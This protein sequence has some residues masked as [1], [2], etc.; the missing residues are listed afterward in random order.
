MATA[1]TGWLCTHSAS[2]VSQN[3]TTATIRVY[4][5]WKNNG[6]TYNINYVTAVVYCGGS[7]YTVMSSGSVNAQSS[8][9]A[10]VSLGYHDFVINKSTATQS[11]SCYAKITSNSSYVSGTK[12][13]TAA[14]VSVSPKTSYKITYNGNA[15]DAKGVPG[16][17]IRYYG[18]TGFKISSTK[19][20]RT[21][22]TFSTWN[23]NSSGTG[24]N[25]AAG[26]AYNTN[27]NLAL[28]AK[29]T[30]NTYTVTFNA[31]G[32][33]GAPAAQT[34]TYGTDLTLSSTKPTRTNYNFLGWATS[35]SATSAAYA[36]GGKYTT[37][38]T[39]TLYAVWQLA[40]TKPRITNVSVYRCNSSGTASDSG[41]YF[42]ATFKWATDKTVSSISI[43]YTPTGGSTT[44]TSL[45][46]SGTSG[47]ATSSAIGS[48]GIS[49]DKSYKIVI[50]VSDAS[51]SNSY[52]T[53]L[54]SRKFYIDT[55]YKTSDGK[56]GV[57]VG[58]AVE[59]LGIFDSALPIYAPGGTFTGVL[60]GTHS[61][62]FSA[63]NHNVSNFRLSGSEGAAS[64]TDV[65]G[66][67]WIGFYNTPT[68]AKNNTNRHGWFGFGDTQANHL[69][70]TN[71]CTNSDA[72]ILF[73]IKNKGS[74]AG[75]KFHQAVGTA[76]NAHLSPETDNKTTL[77]TTAFRWQQLYAGTTTIYTSDK[78]EKHDIDLLSN[79]AET[80]E[81]LFS[82]LIPKVYRMNNGRQTLCMGFVA[83]DIAEVLE[84]LDIEENYLNVLAHD[85]WTD[86]ETGEEKD[87]YSLAYNDFIALTVH[88]VQKQQKTIDAQQKEID[89]LKSRIE[90]LEKLLTKEE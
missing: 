42:K 6:W 77:G 88:M 37:N 12:S 54:A 29:W 90:K 7:S 1:S 18:Q 55:A 38:A 72:Y 23:T 11:I 17:S 32:G 2:V 33:S 45:T 73:R 43:A 81:K 31:N 83:Q 27:A 22:Y 79:S 78:R 10:S 86:Q 89:D 47:T 51:G 48:G 53:S 69:A 80:F 58:K 20:T 40:Y 9:T 82:S 5:Y 70:I 16:T 75:I 36:A 19:P 28:Y 85:S 46:A 65:T 57:A 64:V 24:T 13:S 60:T 49:I 41:T 76:Y 26:A 14:N 62:M 15:T 71:E 87:L 66:T 50:T 30:A 56:I 21:G 8:T 74:N 61:L 35:A 3:D 84:E 52:P 39:V 59:T 34:K 63:L 67:S 4:A 25:Y 44:T 68:D